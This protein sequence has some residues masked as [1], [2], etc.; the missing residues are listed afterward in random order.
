MKLYNLNNNRIADYQTVQID[1]ET[2]VLADLTT[3]ERETL[4]YYEYVTPAQTGQTEW[5]TLVS[6]PI[7]LVGGTYTVTYVYADI[8]L[9]EMK[10][11]RM[12]DLHTDQ[13]NNIRPRVEVPLEDGS[14]IYVYGSRSDQ[15]DIKDRYALMVED[16]IPTLW[17]KD[18]D[19]VMRELGHLDVK[20]CYR[21]ITIYR[22]DNI[23]YVWAKEVEINDCVILDELKLVEWSI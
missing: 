7:V 19:N 8:P 16:S 6:T 18:A 14:V 3:A 23:E 17:L 12:S 4:G 20:R 2:V 5:N 22:N 15:Q 13:A 21:A 10:D 9:D 1:G 11:I